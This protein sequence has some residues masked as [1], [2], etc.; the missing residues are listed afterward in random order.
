M[1]TVQEYLIKAER[2]ERLADILASLPERYTEW[3]V[4]VLFYSAL[5][6]VNAFL[7][8]QGLEATHH[9]ARYQLIASM[10]NFA[11]EYEN[12]SQKSVNARYKMDEF[13]P[14]DVDRT[15]ASDF[16]VVKEEVLA[17]LGRQPRDEAT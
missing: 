14:Q 17:L 1:P 4:T 5:H 10:T 3:E 12:L 2:N 6:Y 13:T 11:R 15:K 9:H 16:R 8:M 7:E